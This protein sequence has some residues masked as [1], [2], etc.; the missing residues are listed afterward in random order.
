MKGRASPQE[1]AEVI[2]RLFL[3]CEFPAPLAEAI[4]AAARPGVGGST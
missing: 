2:R 1:T 3:E 4:R